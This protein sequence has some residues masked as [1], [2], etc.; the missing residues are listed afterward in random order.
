MKQ[1]IQTIDGVKIIIL[2]SHTTKVERSWF[3]RLF[4]RTPFQKYKYHHDEYIKDG[5]F[6][7]SGG[8][9]IVSYCNERTFNELKREIERRNKTERVSV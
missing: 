9:E 7:K 1:R 6:I 4:S 3:D 2:N 5:Q 8:D